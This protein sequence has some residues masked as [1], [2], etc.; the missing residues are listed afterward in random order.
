MP[1]QSKL[2]TGSAPWI[3]NE[4]R[5]AQSM[6][7]DEVEDF[8]YNV[9]NEMEWLNEHM[10]E[11]FANERINVIDVFKTP[12]KLRG[13]TPRTARQRQVLGNRAP[14]TDIFAPNPASSAAKATSAKLTGRFE[15]PNDI[16]NRYPVRTSPT[17]P[18]AASFLRTIYKDSGY[19]DEM[20][21]DL[22]QTQSTQYA[23]STQHGPASPTKSY[24]EDA[25]E[26]VIM[27][28]R[29][30][31]AKI[32]PAR[33][34]H[35]SF[36][37]A[38]ENPSRKP[39]AEELRAQETQSTMADEPVTSPPYQASIAQFSSKK[40]PAKGPSPHKLSPI[41][42]PMFETQSTTVVDDAMDLDDEEESSTDSPVKLTRKSSLTFASIPAREPLAKASIGPRPS[43]VDAS[44]SFG[45][46]ASHLGRNTTSRTTAGPSTA[47]FQAS[48]HDAMD[49]D[50]TSRPAAPENEQSETLKLHNKTSTQGLKDRI[51][52]LKQ[53][54]EAPSSK[55]LHTS[56]DKPLYPSLPPATQETEMVPSQQTQLQEKF[57]SENYT[58]YESDDDWI[59][60][61]TKPGPSFTEASNHQYGPTRESRLVD[62]VSNRLAG[63]DSPKTRQ[64][65][66]SRPGLHKKMV[67]TTVLESPTRSAMAPDP[68]TQKPIS[69][70][71][72][73]PNLGADGT[74]TPHGSPPRSPSGR[75]LL[76]A[77]LSASKAKFYSVLKSAKNMF[78]SSAGASAQAKMDALSPGRLRSA[79]A[80]PLASPSVDVRPAPALFPSIDAGA[81]ASTAQEG[82]RT[83][84]STERE[85]KRKQEQD[86]AKQD[87][88][89]RRAA[90]E[91]E[92]I[93][94]KERAKAAAAAQQKMNRAL[95]AKSLPRPNNPARP[96]T[97]SSKDSDGDDM[98]PPPPPKSM[99][100]TT[101]GRKNQTRRIPAPRP[102]KE[103]AK[104]KPAPVVIRMPSQRIGEPSN[105]VLNQSLHDPIPP[106][107][108]PKT[109]M[110]TKPP[111]MTAHSNSS[112]SSIRTL[113]A[114]QKRALEAANKKKENEKRVAE[115]KAE[116]KRAAERK[117]EQKRELERKR[118]E[119][120]EEARKL[121]EER[122]AAEQ[123][124]MQEARKLAQRKAE[125]AKRA[126]Q[127][128]REAQRQAQR[129][130]SRH[131]AQPARGDVGQSRP[132]NKA[133]LV[134][135]PMRPHIQM[136][137]AKPPKRALPA[138]TDDHGPSRAAPQRTGPAYQ[139]LDAKRRKTE[140]DELAMPEH[141]GSVMQPPVRQSNN[142]KDNK[143]AHAYTPNHGQVP[144][145]Q[146][147]KTV[148]SQQIHM[149]HK[150]PQTNMAQF[151]NGHIP[152]APSGSQS[153]WTT[154]ASS[155]SQQL[156]TPAHQL[157]T[158][159]SASNNGQ[160]LSPYYTP[161]DYGEYIELPDIP[162]DSDEEFSDD[163][164]VVPD[165]A[166]SPNLHELL[167]AQQ[168]IDPETVFGPIGPLNMDK[169]FGGNKE[170][171]KKFRQ[172]TS[173]ANWNGP[174]KLTDS[175]RKR[176]RRARQRLE[177]DGGWD[178][179]AQNKALRKSP[180]P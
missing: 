126:E 75:K 176:D 63:I 180:K 18:T 73:T 131:N 12:G 20:D 94:E 53:A 160:T 14:L 143:F 68:S 118:Q 5:A 102:T 86:Q 178:M 172:R 80:E 105:S 82:R 100:P 67:S 43:H 69:V 83:R 136:N 135:D 111:L 137:P 61:I 128:R 4:L 162:S 72:P 55:P 152:F 46:R 157:K 81:M 114:T 123:Q 32:E 113:T 78:A 139:Q 36:V 9:R 24:H 116:E 144:A 110:T 159:A 88:E 41:A 31:S 79:Y 130:E 120:I 103:A 148:A 125:E 122:K 174:D 95:P 107:P 60:P 127:E 129:P 84:S 147:S 104:S 158:P 119:R 156:K 64:A 10:N 171:Q 38:K 112:T 66:P 166:K 58:T 115:R 25:I 44:K 39:S 161:S 121:E 62:E 141:R 124:R 146:V 22:P 3:V 93:R 109:G 117:I 97:A 149:Q 150:T 28:D 151:A 11:I 77:P 90:V 154:T 165:W 13:K 76:D 29:V 52:M 142:R 45:A 30:E 57:V 15:I 168:M 8:S 26:D 133:N 40:S 54:R 70:S 1:P 153:Q 98:P 74:T 108:P 16:E 65:S 34:S 138:D 51:N 6:T 87:A 19:H 71:N 96:E 155:S 164:F 23:Q 7:N 140:D 179:V 35:D 145:I 106:P 2:P 85:H 50:Q 21:V 92:K 177:D 59:A 42:Q 33:V 170:R 89:H 56:T 91:L 167:K 169:V 48:S 175:E 132:L 134:H 99:L 101:Q 49:I 163:G 27:S 47:T 17:K 173:S 37:S